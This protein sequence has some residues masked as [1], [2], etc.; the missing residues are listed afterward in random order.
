MDEEKGVT[1][2]LDYLRRIAYALE[3]L[4]DA[5]EGEIDLGVNDE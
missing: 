1:Q 5:A 3:R 2:M 4:A